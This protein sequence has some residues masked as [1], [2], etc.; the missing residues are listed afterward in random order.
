MYM[1]LHVY[2]CD[3]MKCKYKL[4]STLLIFAL[5]AT[6]ATA[7]PNYVTPGKYQVTGVMQNYNLDNQNNSYQL[8]CE[9]GQYVSEEYN[10]NC[11]IRELKFTNHTPIYINVFYPAADNKRGYEAYYGWFGPQKKEVTTFWT[12]DQNKHVIMYYRDWGSQTKGRCQI[13]GLCNASIVKS[14]FGNVTEKNETVIEP[15]TEN[16]STQP[17]ENTSVQDI[18]VNNSQPVENN[19]AQ[20]V[21]LENNE[22]N[23]TA[24]NSAN[25]VN[26][27]GWV[28]KVEQ[29]WINL[30][31]TNWSNVTLNFWGN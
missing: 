21:N 5:L 17:A 23:N 11:D 25:T 9:I 29:Y 14:Y 3:V 6:T 12:R 2:T 31:N 26:N 7:T 30:S 20:S 13:I 10:W 24:V 1:Y 8:A 22:I 28:D 4:F 19:T 16:E 15:V 18:S 27:Q